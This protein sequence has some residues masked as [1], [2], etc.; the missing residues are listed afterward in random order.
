M[1]D[2][3]TR[4]SRRTTLAWLSVATAL[5]PMALPIAVRAAGAVPDGMGTAPAAKPAAGPGYGRDPDLLDPK[6]PWP[7][8]MTEEQL[9]QTSLLADIFLPRT[10]SYPAPS[11]LGIQDFVDE[12][13]SAPYPD[14]QRDRMLILNG[15]A[16]MDSEAKRRWKRPFVELD[17]GQ[18]TELLDSTT[19]MPDDHKKIELMMRYGFF[20]RLRTIVV[21]AYYSM[22]RNHPQLGYVGNVA[23]QAFPPPSA[24]DDAFIDRAIARLNL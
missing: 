1:P 9:K 18:Q 17:T 5:V 2:S 3:L 20:R 11:E 6:V 21:G 14:Q 15:L 19:K 13:V 7:R 23:L 4:V 24:E 12:W 8:T 16:W 10:A 22:E